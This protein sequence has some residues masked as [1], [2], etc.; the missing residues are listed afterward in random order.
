MELGLVVVH[1]ETLVMDNKE[2]EAA[3]AAFEYLA[4]LLNIDMF[5]ICLLSFFFYFVLSFFFLLRCLIVGFFVVC[6]FVRLLIQ[7]SFLM[8]EITA[9][10]SC[11][12]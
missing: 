1:A 4:I 9:L 6:F 8:C 10:V 2:R 11:K 12:F 3:I 7:L 5:V